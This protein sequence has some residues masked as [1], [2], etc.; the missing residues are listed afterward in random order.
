MVRLAI[1]DEAINSQLQENPD[2]LGEVEVVFA[3]KD[4][5]SLRRKGALSANAVVVD[6]N[7]LGEDPARELDTIVDQCGAEMA[8]VLYQYA[9]RDLITRLSEGKSRALKVPVHLG[10]LRMHLLGLLVRD[11]FNANAP[12]GARA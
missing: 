5:P 7:L 2:G 6:L 3:G 4:L 1:L 8:L 9:K 11:I 12:Q 10:G